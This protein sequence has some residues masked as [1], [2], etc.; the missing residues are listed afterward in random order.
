MPTVRQRAY[1][2]DKENQKK[3]F[4]E[5]A[6]K[7]NIQNKDDWNRVTKDMVLKEGGHFIGHYYNNSLQQGTLI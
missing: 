2:K 4:D 7:W 6:I 5:L 3:F 1:W